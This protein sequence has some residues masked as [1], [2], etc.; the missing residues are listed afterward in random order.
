[1]A[2]RLEL[3]GARSQIDRVLAM[4]DLAD[5]IRRKGEFV[6]SKIEARVDAMLALSRQL[7]ADDPVLWGYYRKVIA[8]HLQGHPREEE[9][10]NI[11]SLT[12][13]QEKDAARAF[14]TFAEGIKGFFDPTG[15]LHKESVG[16]LREIRLKAGERSTLG[17][18]AEEY[19][20]FQ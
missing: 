13:Q 6:R 8:Q 11:P 18:M 3:G 1:M 4:K 12:P 9:F 14:A 5:G 16:V 15:R 7:A 10:K 20:Q 19:M 17:R 2:N